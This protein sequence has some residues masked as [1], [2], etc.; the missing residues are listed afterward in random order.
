MVFGTSEVLI[1]GRDKRMFKK[2]TF[3]VN[4]TPDRNNNQQ[5]HGSNYNFPLQEEEVKLSLPEVCSDISNCEGIGGE[6]KPLIQLARLKEI[7]D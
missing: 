3:T 4:P 6:L 5:T 1:E 7:L 2:R